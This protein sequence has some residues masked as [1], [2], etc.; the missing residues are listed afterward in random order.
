MNDYP[1]NLAVPPLAFDIL[2]PNCASYDPPILVANATTS[3]IDIKPH[4]E[5]HVNVTGLIHQLPDALTARC[6]DSQLS[7]LDALLADYLHG[8]NATVF[9]RGSAV[10]TPDTPDWVAG[11]ISSVMVPFPFPGRTFDNLIRTFSLARVHFSLPD[12]AADPDSPAAQPRLSAVVR[13]LIALPKEMNVPLDVLRVRATA[14][15]YYNKQKLGRLDL[16]KWQAA[17]SSRVP[18]REG[19]GLT[20]LVE[21]LVEDAPLQVTNGDVFGKV[22]RML[23]FER[24]AV[25]LDIDAVVDADVKTGLGRFV[26]KD[27]HGQGKVPIPGSST[28]YVKSVVYSSSQLGRIWP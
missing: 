4:S 20:L 12:P 8:N 9:I 3:A 25:V 19:D 7:P 2:V 28:A 23:F 6:P 13:A 22:V 24:K 17:N 10:Q 21:S 18:A 16:R 14:D 1:V 26:I 27:I 11:V 15:V 5:L